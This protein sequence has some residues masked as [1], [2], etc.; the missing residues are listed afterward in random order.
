MN[1]QADVYQPNLEAG[2]E[3]QDHVCMQLHQHGVVLQNI[4][5]KKFQLKKENLLGMEIKFD[6]KFRKTGR[7]YIETAE[8]ADPANPRYVP[9]G[10]YRQDDNWLFAIG[11]YA[12][13]YVFDKKALRRLDTAAPAWLFRPTPTPTSKGFCIP[14]DKAEEMAKH[15]RL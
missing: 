12:D 7:F 3:Y 13:L 10:I 1:Y 15:F 9:S 6:R 8:K 11:D 2:I 5:S 4:Q 14:L